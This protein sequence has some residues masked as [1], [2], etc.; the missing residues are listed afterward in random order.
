MKVESYVSEDSI[1]K[2]RKKQKKNKVLP[3]QIKPKP[4]KSL[5]ILKSL[6]ERLVNQ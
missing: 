4:N 6:E 1:T 3:E 5:E 2:S